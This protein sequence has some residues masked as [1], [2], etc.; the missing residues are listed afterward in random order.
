MNEP[1]ESRITQLLVSLK[2]PAA[3]KTTAAERLYDGVYDKMRSM[4]HLMMRRENCSHTL[5]PTALVHEAYLKLVDQSRV[6]WHDRAHFYATAARV[7]RHILV[8]HARRKSRSKHGGGWRRVTLDEGLG[9]SKDPYLDTLS[10]D[11][12]LTRLFELDDRMGKVVE[13][14]IFGGLT[15][16]EIAD[17]LGVSKRTVDGDWMVAKRW[18]AEELAA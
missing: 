11:K 17:V 15:A 4:A 9:I 2:D 6:E 5:Q 7:M 14:R 16:R 13:M 10:L 18:L 1:F 8:D 12:A 3:D